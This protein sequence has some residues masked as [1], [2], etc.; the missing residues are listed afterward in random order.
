[1]TEEHVVYKYRVRG[2]AREVVNLPEGATILHID[3]WFGSPN[4]IYLWALV[5]TDQV[6]NL[7]PRTLRFVATGERITDIHRLTYVRT[8]VVG[9]E[10]WHIFEEK[11]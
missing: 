5:R 8:A 9:N 6:D 1:M 2:H 7:K 11:G 4:I 10:V 3:S